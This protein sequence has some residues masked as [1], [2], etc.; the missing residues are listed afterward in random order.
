M[1]SALS[2]NEI[3]LMMICLIRWLEESHSSLEGNSRWAFIVER[4]N[5]PLPRVRSLKVEVKGKE[6][7]P[8]SGTLEI[9]QLKQI[10][11]LQ[12]R[13]SEEHSEPMS[14]ESIA[15]KFK[16]DLAHHDKNSKSR[17]SH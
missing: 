9:P 4:Y 17:I 15:E 13:K 3:I 2:R 10:L 6:N 1:Y 7:P 14:I 8:P 12:A 5:R 11:L 16:I